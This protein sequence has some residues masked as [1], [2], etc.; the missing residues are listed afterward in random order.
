M[1]L[2]DIAS[3]PGAGCTVALEACLASAAGNFA[4]GKFAGGQSKSFAHEVARPPQRREAR[5]DTS[6]QMAMVNPFVSGEGHLS[7]ADAE[8][9]SNQVESGHLTFLLPPLPPKLQG[10]S[11]KDSGEALLP[12]H[13]LSVSDAMLALALEVQ[14]GERI[15]HLG[16][17]SGSKSLLLAAAL[18]GRSAASDN[19]SESL[20]DRPWLA[21]AGVEA[22]LLSKPSKPSKGLLV[23]NEANR[24][25]AGVLEGQFAN[26]LPKELLGTS[27]DLG[28]VTITKVECSDGKV[29]LPLKR[30]QSFD[31]ILV[32][33]AK[34]INI[35]MPLDVLAESQLR[36]AAQLLR[37]GGM[38][39][40]A[41]ASAE[42]RETNGVVKRFLRRTGS[43]FEVV[44]L[45]VLPLPISQG[46]ASEMGMLL[47]SDQSSDQGHFYLSRLKKQME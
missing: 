34:E 19:V 39:V 4:V 41:I 28:Q 17:G 16:A 2:V 13:F 21:Q 5:Q 20:N 8:S 1:A 23:C 22:G 7:H 43:A 27:S 3:S 11:T 46:T 35:D 9:Q 44:P 10:S 29:P 42:D 40:F 15:L 47:T 37:P 18:F 36:C 32:E 26:F 25:K 38:I 12:Y 14:K 24:S 30:F 6:M 33:M 31:R 45:E